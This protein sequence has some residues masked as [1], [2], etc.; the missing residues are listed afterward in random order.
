MSA[1]SILILVFKSRIVL[2]YGGVRYVARNDGEGAGA[3][4]RQRSDSHP[5]V[6]FAAV[7]FRTWTCPL[8]GL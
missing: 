7:D 4:T 8:S 3:S 2:H 5:N 1:S 6:R